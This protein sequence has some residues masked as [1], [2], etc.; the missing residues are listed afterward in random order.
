M[1]KYKISSLSFSLI[2]SFIVLLLCNNFSSNDSSISSY[3]IKY[4]FAYGLTLSISFLFIFNFKK[5]KIYFLKSIIISAL[6]LYYQIIY[7]FVINQELIRS[8]FETNPTEAMI[9]LDDKWLWIL[10]VLLS[11]FSYFILKK[12]TIIPSNKKVI[13]IIIASQLVLFSLTYFFN[14]SYLRR[15]IK[16]YGNIVEPIYFYSKIKNYMIDSI[17][18][19]NIALDYTIYEDLTPSAIADN[20]YN[21]I[22]IVL[23][24]GESA[25]ANNF[26]LNDYDRETNPR[27]Q[28]RK[29][30][31]SYKNAAS[32]GTSTA[33]SVPC[34]LSRTGRSDGFSLPLTEPSIIYAFKKLGFE[35]YFYSRQATKYNKAIYASCL[36]ADLCEFSIKGY[37][38]VLVDRLKNLIAKNKKPKLIVLH[39][40]GSHFLYH[41]Q[42]PSDFEKFKPV[43]KKR[44]YNCQRDYA[45]N[46]YDN[47]IIYTDFV[48]DKIITTIQ[49]T[50]SVMF[51]TSDHGESIGENNRYGHASFYNIAPKE[52]TNVPF[53]VWMSD[54]FPDKD[55][56]FRNA[57]SLYGKDIRHAHVFHSLLGLINNQAKSYNQNLDIFSDSYLDR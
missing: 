20:K 16:E 36:E 8:V 48:L 4:V 40:N 55:I 29:N 31:I 17:R 37:D 38:E 9:I 49:D 2:G 25:R 45:I 54:N 19:R 51:Y 15:F 56:K 42:Y 5:Q 30:I 24:I 12:I 23:V 43:C 35:T 18:Y 26:S 10:I 3:F 47:S 46:A 1:I 41:E 21:N 6:I 22:N 13:N 27:L 44:A 50:K 14:Y 34:M 32:C 11:M 39:T 57:Q 52:Q 53:I 33:F 28:Q 7:G